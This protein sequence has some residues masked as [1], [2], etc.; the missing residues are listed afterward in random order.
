MAQQGRPSALWVRRGSGSTG[1]HYD[2]SAFVRRFV[3][4]EKPEDPARDLGELELSDFTEAMDP[5]FVLNGASARPSFLSIP[6]IDGKAELHLQ[7][8]TSSGEAPSRTTLT[9]PGGHVA[10][11]LDRPPA[12][13][14]DPTDAKRSHIV[15]S[16]VHV[17]G[18]YLPVPQPAATLAV[19]VVTLDD[20]VCSHIQSETFTTFFNGFA[21]SDELR[22]AAHGIQH[23]GD[24]SMKE[25][26]YA[27][28]RFSERVRSGQMV[29]A[30]ITGDGVPDLLQIAQSP[31]TKQFASAMLVGE[32]T[33]S[34][35][36]F[37]QTDWQ[38]QTR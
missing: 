23:P 25:A 21:T 8:S 14:P 11:W 26:L 12:L 6:K 24:A 18:R 38:R 1:D 19:T 33:A 20:G 32:H 4:G 10:L 9:C 37:R 7:A 28:D 22:A 27:V 16:R 30:D 29:V 17:S 13:I 31:K 3:I 2:T 34:G 35:L 36:R 5:P 15:F